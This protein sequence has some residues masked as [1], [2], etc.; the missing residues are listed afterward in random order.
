MKPDFIKLACRLV[1]MALA[2]S[3]GSAAAQQN[4][5][6]PISGVASHLAEVI[7][8][9]LA[10]LPE[11][12][13]EHRAFLT[14]EEECR[15]EATADTLLMG[16]G[17]EE[18]SN[19]TRLYWRWKRQ[20]CFVLLGE[21]IKRG[22]SGRVLIE[23]L[24][25]PL[26]SGLD[27]GFGWNF[28]FEE[29]LDETTLALELNGSGFYTE[30]NHYYT[31]YVRGMALHNLGRLSEA[32]ESYKLAIEIADAAIEAAR[33]NN[34]LHVADAPAIKAKAEAWLIDTHMRLLDEKSA[35]AAAEHY[36]TS[37]ADES[38][39]YPGAHLWDLN[40]G[41]GGVLG[42]ADI[43]LYSRKLE[44]AR[45]SYLEVL[46]V[47]QNFLFSRTYQQLGYLTGLLE[48][49]AKRTGANDR[50]S[51]FL[52]EAI[53]RETDDRAKLYQVLWMWLLG[54]KPQRTDVAESQLV[55]WLE[56]RGIEDYWD[57]TLV[58]FMVWHNEGFNRGKSKLWKDMPDGFLAKEPSQEKRWAEWAK[59]EKLSTGT[60][61]EFIEVAKQEALRRIR[62]REDVDDL[63]SEAWFYVG[64]RSEMDAEAT[65]DPEQAKA[66]K[67]SA[68]QAYLESA[69]FPMENFKWEPEYA[70]RNANVL[71][72]ELNYKPA[73]GFEFSDL[74]ITKV[75]RNGFAKFSGLVPGEIVALKIHSPLARASRDGLREFS[76]GTYV[77]Q[78]GDLLQFVLR[79]DWGDYRIDTVVGGIP[80]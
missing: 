21:N 55:F 15:L 3:L 22:D 57:R 29:A 67:A 40:H 46:Q 66:L 75:D 13:G 54:E 70:R 76:E 51:G 8:E 50:A 43:Y 78:I 65:E 32:L 11:Y 52:A 12:T 14:V 71:G 61:A 25:P 17:R 53:Y 79:D 23:R 45:R 68:L 19:D 64:T 10:E 37:Y 44:Q 63:M 27:C 35:I 60:S 38:A 1:S 42:N 20:E 31:Y 6:T 56:R 33:K 74:K 59:I 80:N 24:S 48:D 9:E 72:R 28:Y 77:P 34:S 5:E 69:S 7:R 41:E 58:A 36:Y 49:P 73:L 4:T 30:L 26:D 18:F 2:A 16:I 39:T 47:E 62:N